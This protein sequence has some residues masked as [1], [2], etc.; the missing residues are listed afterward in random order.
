MLILVKT[1][2]KKK[3]ITT[4]LFYDNFNKIS[5]IHMHIVYHVAGI[6]SLLF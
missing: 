4:A 3:N 2:Q 1:S 5:Q 6:R